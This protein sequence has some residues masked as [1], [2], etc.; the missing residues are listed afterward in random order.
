MK[1][2]PK[3]IKV[4]NIKYGEEDPADI[5]AEWFVEYVNK[6]EGKTVVRLKINKDENGNEEK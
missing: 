1:R 2:E 4:N 6:K 3:K 5:L